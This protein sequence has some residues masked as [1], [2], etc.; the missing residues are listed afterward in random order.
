MIFN[1]SY[2]RNIVCTDFPAFHA[3][4]VVLR[5][6]HEFKYL[7]HI[8]SSDRRDDLDIKR[9][10]KALFTRMNILKSRYIR[11]SREFERKLFWSYCICFYGTSLWSS[12][13]ARSMSLLSSCYVKCLKHFFG[14]PKYHSVTAMLLELNIPSM[15]TLLHN[16][17][18]NFIRNVAACNNVLVDMVLS[19]CRLT[20]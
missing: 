17:M 14:Y 9:E 19:I 10:I 18:H 5:T 7:G 20:R 16:S 13:T 8:I 12:Y 2:N 4:S 3:G 6:V 11:C 1:P 15:Q